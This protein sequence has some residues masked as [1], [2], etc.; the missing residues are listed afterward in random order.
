MG[1]PLEITGLWY[2]HRHINLHVQLA[3][4]NQKHEQPRGVYKKKEIDIQ[5]LISATENGGID[6]RL[7]LQSNTKGIF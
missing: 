3:A 6:S 7:T 2:L 1:N 4:R 5:F